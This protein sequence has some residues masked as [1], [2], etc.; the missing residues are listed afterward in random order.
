MAAGSW[1]CKYWPINPYSPDKVIDDILEGAPLVRLHVPALPHDGVDGIRTACWL[2]KLL[3]CL[4]TTCEVLLVTGTVKSRWPVSIITKKL[5]A[6]NRGYWSPYHNNL[7]VSFILR[8][9]S[10]FIWRNHKFRVHHGRLE[11]GPLSILEHLNTHHPVAPDVRLAPVFL[12]Q[13]LWW[14]PGEDHLWNNSQIYPYC[15]YPDTFSC[16]LAKRQ[17]WYQ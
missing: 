13:Y 16:F 11:T 12:P 5:Q 2:R 9:V 8:A 15:Y 4:D 7:N 17:N 14:C 6:L 10:L 1:K 3:T